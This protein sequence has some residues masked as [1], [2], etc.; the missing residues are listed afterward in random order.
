[1]TDESGPKPLGILSWGTYLPQAKIVKDLVL[2]KG[3]DPKNYL[4]FGWEK[5]CVAEGNDYPTAMCIK[6]L[7]KALSQCEVHVSQLQLVI[8]TSTTHDYPE[9]VTASE[10]MKESGAA[11]SCVG[12]DIYHGCI[13]TLTALEVAR[14]WLARL[15]GGYAA[16][17]SA[18]R[19]VDSIDKT[20]RLIE[21]LWNFSDGAS[22]LIVGVDVPQKQKLTYHGS[23]FS[24][25]NDMSGYI[26][27]SYGGARSFGTP[28]GE[29]P[30]KRVLLPIPL[31]KQWQ[32]FSEGYTKVYTD[33]KTRFNTK[34]DWLVCNQGTP[35]VVEQLA[36]MTRIKQPHFARSGEKYG[37][38]GCC[39][40]TIGFEELEKAGELKGPGI[41]FS[42]SASAWGAGLLKTV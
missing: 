31:Q 19:W 42:C 28:P 13:T 7:K 10:V 36:F 23:C 22:A 15:G 27:R 30:T 33:F 12:F 24:N 21:S 32:Y 8:C 37:H 9:V 25:C 35:A 38:V 16:I 5:V 4:T 14:D 34:P 2:A 18:E 11:S 41:A 29:N 39:D 26:R 17:V 1:M 3:G 40:L 6:A 20:D